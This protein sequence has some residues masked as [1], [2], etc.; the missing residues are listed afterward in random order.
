MKQHKLLPAKI[1]K[2]SEQTS[3]RYGMAHTGVFP[4]GP[5]TY[6]MNM[7]MAMLN[8]Q[9]LAEAEQIARAMTMQFPQHG[10][11]WM[12]L[13]A[14]LV[15]QGSIATALQPAK[16]AAALMP[17]DADAHNNLGLALGMQ[18]MTSEAEASFRKALKLKPDFAGAHFNLG[19]A[20]KQQRRW[21]EAEASFRQTIRIVPNFPGAHYSLGNALNE[22]SR[23]TEAE[24]SFQR[25]LTL[26]PDFAAAHHD[27][28]NT[29]MAQDRLSDAQACYRRAL[30]ISPKFAEAHCSM[31]N[32]L[33]ERGQ[34]SEAE[35]YCREALLINPEF[36]EAHSILG[37]ILHDQ[38]RH[39][40]AEDSLQRAIGIK[41]DYV[42]ALV[43]LGDVEA[44]QGR[45]VDAENFYRRALT[46]EPLLCT[47]WAALAGLRKMTVGDADWM[48]SAEAIVQRGLPK[49]QESTLRYAM[50]KF[51]DD[52]QD[53]DHAFKHYQRANELVKACGG[54]YDRVQHT[55]DIDRL[56]QTYHHEQVGRAHAG[57][58]LSAK[59]TFIVGMPRSG[60]SLIEQIIASH[61]AAFGAGEL[62]FW[63]QARAAHRTAISA[64]EL[65]ETLV[66]QL[67]ESCLQ[68]LSGFSADALRV[69]D[70]MPVNFSLLGLIHAVFPNARIIHAQRNPLDTCLSIYFQNFSSGHSYAND[71]EDLAH[72]YREYHRLMAHWRATLP[73]ETLLEVPYEALI[74]D[75]PDW[76]RKII[77]FMGLDWDERCLDF[78]KTDRKVATSSKWQVRQKIYTS[79]KERW[80]N[81]EKFVD[82]LVCLLELDGIKSV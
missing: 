50:G 80:R 68:N 6:E 46:I 5:S 4:K 26:K 9:R 34:L 18:G 35:A 27:L 58:S 21:M 40:E 64:A 42:D 44:G 65:N 22:Q 72:Y 38:G 17:N 33:K 52:L 28:G 16:N 69:V 48:T 39:V 11:G 25:T 63:P 75:Q 7:L 49:R 19:N 56:C 57:A 45:F 76:S 77:E 13:G 14:V 8:Q 47:A 12:M 51:C 71:L 32:L 30:E 62:T 24:A 15:R 60:T 3:L 79:S 74:D 43:C 66:R 81:Y 59:P 23:W 53:F 10:F 31:G 78:H 82:Q 73:V 2:S 41:P 70:K 61:P 36:A 54:Q 20:L 29:Y 37:N 55:Q 1:A 67:A